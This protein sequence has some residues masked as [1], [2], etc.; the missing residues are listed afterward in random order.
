[1][2]GEEVKAAREALGMTQWELAD[3]LHLESKNSDATVRAWENGWGGV[4]GTSG[5]A[6]RLMVEL[7]KAKG[8]RKVL[9]VVA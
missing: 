3:A 6:I 9:A 7:A 5:V 4:P 2:D 1:M 8:K